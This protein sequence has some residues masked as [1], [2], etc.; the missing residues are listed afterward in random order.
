M[1]NWFAIINLPNILLFGF[2]FLIGRFW[3]VILKTIG[4]VKEEVKANK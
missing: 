2:G 3:K 1:V 4:F